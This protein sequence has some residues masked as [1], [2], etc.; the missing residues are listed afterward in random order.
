MSVDVAAGRAYVLGS[1]A[2][3]VR[4][5]DVENKTVTANSSGNPRI[6]T[7]VLYIDKAASPNSDSSNVAK[8]MVVAGT[9]AASPSVPSDST[10]QTAVGAGNPFIRL[11]NLAVANGTSSVTSAN[12]TD[13][14][15]PF[16][17]R[18][19][20]GS[21]AQ[22][23]VYYRDA[24]GELA[25]LAP[26]TNGQ[27]LQT[28]GAGANPQWATIDTEL[29][30]CLVRKSVSQSISSGAWATLTWDVEEADPNNLHNNSSN[31]SRITVDAGGLYLVE[32]L[33]CFNGSTGNRWVKFMK[34]GGDAGGRAGG[35][36][37]NNDVAG[38][39]IVRLLA[40]AGG[41]YIEVQGYQN[42]GGALN[43]IG[44]TGESA[45]YFELTKIS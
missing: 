24:N 28:Q 41:D 25:R 18:V 6:D 32:T 4:S 22:G 13:V 3:P 45:S 12:I 8:L 29:P 36:I 31:T 35:N 27:Y 16:K 30:H 42:S 44:G 1:D 21:D 20:V 5:T 40:L 10:I 17:L 23:D 43:V 14:R 38:V 15:T 11:A 2:Y 26:G 7:V 19:N 9:A 34:N 37:A 39:S 33:I